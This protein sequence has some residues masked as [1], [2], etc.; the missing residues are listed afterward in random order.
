MPKYL[1]EVSYAPEAV[2]G[3]IKNPEDRTPPV[4]AAVESLG[5]K[6][7]CLYF[8]FGER[9]ALAVADVP[10]N[11][12]AAAL[13]MA[14]SATGRYKSCRTTPLMTG[15]EMVEAARAAGKVNFRP[16]GG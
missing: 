16:A 13:S 8:S 14:V 10:N 7:E 11:V 1:V 3:M 2:A 12:S 15:E 4:R 6:L 5:G 9:D